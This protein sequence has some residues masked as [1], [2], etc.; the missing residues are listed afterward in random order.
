MLKTK[1]LE[2]RDKGIFIPIL[3]IRFR[4]Q[5]EEQRYLLAKAGYGSTFLQQAGYTLLAEIDGG[6]G[7]INSDL[8]EFGPARTLP[9]AHDYI[10]KHFDELSDGDVVDIEFILGERSEPKI[11]ERLTTEV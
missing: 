1:I 3:A 11:S 6:G 4:P 10:T 9:Y 8:Y 2:I 7:R 5:T